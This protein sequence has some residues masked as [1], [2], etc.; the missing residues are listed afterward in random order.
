[1]SKLAPA[2]NAGRDSARNSAARRDRRRLAVRPTRDPRRRRPKPLGVANDGANTGGATGDAALIGLTVA[3]A[4]H[5]VH[6]P[7]VTGSGK[8]TWLARLVLAEAQAGRGVVLLD[9]Q[10]D[11]ARNVLDRL[12]ADCGDRLIVLDPAETEAPPAWNVL[13]PSGP[14]SREWAAENVVGVF[15]RLYAQWWG[16][17]MDDLLRAACL[18]LVRRPGS[19]LADVVP[20]L[21]VDSFRRSVVAECGEPPGLEGFWRGYEDLSVGQRAQ[22]TG[23]VLSRLRGVLAR[24]FARDLLGSPGSTID[25]AEVL[26]GGILIARLAKGEIGEDVARLVGSLLLSGIWAHATRRSALAPEQRRDATVVVDECHNFLHLPIGVDDALAEMRGYRV[27]LVLAHQHLAQLP[28]EVREAVDANARNK[29]MFTVSPTDAQKLARHVAPFLDADDLSRRAA[30]QMTARI[31]HQGHDQ[32][33]FTVDSL[34]LPRPIPGRGEAL[35]AAARARTGLPRAE[36]SFSTQRRKVDTKPGAARL[37]RMPGSS[38]GNSGGSSTG[39]SLGSLKLPTELPTRLREFPQDN[40]DE[41]GA[42]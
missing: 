35:R 6:V 5:H 36:R 34:P 19:T 27:S 15:R 25:L 2:G 38:P 11:L 22:L 33:P 10:G 12:P 31:V 39:D 13:D 26:D 23:P 42:S 37:H 24:E 1:M 40:R 30:F 18:T 21:T 17:R 28:T 29:I 3:D 14:E 7:G 20:L 4:R 8:S 9:G 32:P 41:Q 16:P